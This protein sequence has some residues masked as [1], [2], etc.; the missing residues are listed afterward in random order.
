MKRPEQANWLD[1]AIAHTVPGE[2]PRPDFAAWQSAHGGALAS[3]ARRAQR[4][5]QSPPGIPRVIEFG[6]QIMRSPLAKLAVA[7]ALVVGI[8]ILVS[9]LTGREA[10]QPAPG[11]TAAEDRPVVE[12]EDAADPTQ[13]ELALARS[14]YEQGD[15]AGLVSLLQSGTDKTKIKVAQY[16]GEIGNGSAIAA[17]QSLAAQW[18]G[19]PDANPFRKAIDAIQER[20]GETEP[21]QTET[22]EP[23]APAAEPSVLATEPSTPK[24]SVTGIA[25]IVLDK[26]TQKPIAGAAVG[27]R[28][29]D[30]NA[31]AHTDEAGRFVLTGLRAFERR[32]ISVIAQDYIS[33]RIVT[34][35]VGDQLT[36]GLLIELDRASRVAGKV[37]DPGGHPI[38]GAT[39]KTFHFTN[40]PVVTGPDGNFEIDGLSPVVDSYSLHATHPNYPAVSLRFSPGA[41]G[42]TVYQDV[43]LT[44]G[45]DVFGRVTDPNGQPLAGVTVG[46]TASRSMWN[47]ITTTTDA[48]GHYRLKNADLGG[49]ILWA[50]H[51]NHALHVQQ[52]M[53]GEGTSEEQIDIQLDAGIPLHGRIVDDA[54]EPVPGVNLVIHAY[55]GVSNL[56]NKRYTSNAEGWFTIPHA[57]RE[58]DLTLNP[59]G[60]G[61]SGKLQEFE[62]GQA[63]YA[64]LVRR[65]GRIYGKV[66]AEAT[67]DPITEFTVKMTA[68]EVGERTYG[69]AAMWNREGVTFKSSKGHF[70]TGREDVPVGA[71]FKMTVFAQGYD[72]LVL[73]P[74]TVQPIAPDP[75]RTVFRLRTATLTAG[76]VVDAEGNPIEDATIAVYAKSERWEPGH[77]RKFATDAAGVFVISGVSDDQEYLY[78]TASG[79]APH[80]GLRSELGSADG[81]PARIA[82]AAAARAFG[83]VLNEQGQPRPGMRVEVSKTRDDNDKLLYDRYPVVSRS[84]TTDKNGYY[85]L[86]ELPVGRCMVY[87]KS[88]SGEDRGSKRAT[89]SPGQATQVDFGGE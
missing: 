37:T 34:R 41:A 14:L 76:V 12:L 45:A 63:E 70:D 7:A 66:L 9:H 52:R 5:T 1:D 35:V 74:V 23:N 55:N 10:P 30:P 19:A 17:L 79:F 20:L 61:I 28:L 38:A 2:P 42:L 3:L 64:V 44:P 11:P 84:T 83:V 58:G 49:L 16:L 32:Y 80:A 60:G 24:E 73:D 86:L 18:Q 21:E 87:L 46:N 33:R 69:Y 13:E 50:V 22:A 67:D 75:N 39:V 89:F 88:S 54:G 6:R 81:T 62:L 65:A 25:G 72:A 82:L 36:E 15:I 8:F 40:R 27:Y 57:P 4:R 85:E 26:L 71:G 29:S 53:L 68:T 48:Q 47:C 77:W 78:I 56:D 51:S 59:F 31:T 43:I